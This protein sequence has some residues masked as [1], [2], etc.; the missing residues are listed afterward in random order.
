[1]KMMKKKWLLLLML[2]MVVSPVV[3]GRQPEAKDR[4]TQWFGPYGDGVYYR[5]CQTYLGENQWLETDVGN[6]GRNYQW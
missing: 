1:M 2:L 3:F 6:I 4:C 5:Y